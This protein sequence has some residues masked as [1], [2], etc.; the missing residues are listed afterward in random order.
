MSKIDEAVSGIERSF[1]GQEKRFDRLER[2]VFGLYVLMVVSFVT[3][4]IVN[5]I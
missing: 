2:I 4:G 3:I 1:D 5:V